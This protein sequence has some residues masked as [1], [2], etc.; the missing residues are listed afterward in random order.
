MYRAREVPDSILAT[1]TNDARFGA[2]GFLDADG[3]S[4]TALAKPER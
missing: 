1:R 3:T 4:G 2:R